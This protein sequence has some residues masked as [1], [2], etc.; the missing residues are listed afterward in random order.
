MKNDKIIVCIVED[1]LS[2]G[3]T[4]KTKI[5]KSEDYYC[6]DHFLNAEDAVEGI[7]KN[8]PDLVIMD[9]GLPG[10]SGIECMDMVL[11][12]FPAIRVVMFT[13]FDDDEQLFK[14]LKKGA[15][16]YILKNDSFKEIIGALNELVLGGGPMSPEIALKVLKSF[17][18]KARNNKLEI[19]TKHQIDILRL[20][21]EGLLNKEIASKI[22]C[23]EGSIKVQI[24]RIYKKLQV[25]NR[26]EATMIYKGH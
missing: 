11:S 4:L 21:S 1:D 9:I 17:K 18:V 3:S 2:I 14:A 24:S 20:I 5:N 6:Q 8:N 26:V 12:K 25:N 10:M 13:I 23:T 19:L 16:G 15:S 7:T 22:G